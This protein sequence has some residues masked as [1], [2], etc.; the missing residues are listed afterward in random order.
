M[1]LLVIFPLTRVL[2]VWIFL[3]Y[4]LSSASPIQNIDS[5]FG[6][7]VSESNEAPHLSA[8]EDIPD[9]PGV[10]ELKQKVIEYG[11]ATSKPDWFYTK[12]PLVTNV[13]QQ[14]ISQNAYAD[15]PIGASNKDEWQY[16]MW[17]RIIDPI[18]ATDKK[19]ALKYGMDDAGFKPSR[20]DLYGDMFM[21]QLS[22]AFAEASQGEVFLLISD[23]AFPDD[24]WDTDS[25]WGGECRESAALVVGFC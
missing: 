14:W 12:Y 16:A 5:P 1:E 10:D 18:W 17:G 23:D 3:F 7:S 4:V 11:V 6:R 13:A 22:Q 15:E 21:K 19:D 8:R 20:R 9:V 2:I 24:K 25:A